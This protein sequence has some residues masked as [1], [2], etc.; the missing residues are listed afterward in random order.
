MGAPLA[1]L[2]RI[3]QAMRLPYRTLQILQPTN[4]ARCRIRTSA[5]V[6]AATF[7]IARLFVRLRYRVV[8]IRVAMALIFSQYERSRIQAKKCCQELSRNWR[9]VVS[10]KKKRF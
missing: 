4:P 8:I 5:L 2:S 9:E 3:R 6:A 7:A 1:D 10:T